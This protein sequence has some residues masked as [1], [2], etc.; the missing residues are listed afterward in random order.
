[1]GLIYK[2]GE[3]Y[4]N[5]ANSYILPPA[6]KETLGGI[7]I[8]ENLDID[9]NGILNAHGGGGSSTSITDYQRDY[10]VGKLTK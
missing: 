5:S 3:L 1:M 6:S 2:N 10:L 9:E 4:G 8:G 7:K